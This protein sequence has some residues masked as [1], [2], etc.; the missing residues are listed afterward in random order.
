MVALF[1]L[2]V[3]SRLLLEANRV[4]N[5]RWAGHNQLLA[6]LLVSNAWLAVMLVK[7]MRPH[8]HSARS[9]VFQL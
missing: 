5:V 1:V 2:P 8:A 9:A 4:R 7:F 6:K 3:A